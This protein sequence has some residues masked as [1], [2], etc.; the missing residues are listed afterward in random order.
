M[1]GPHPHPLLF[2]CC[3]T[4]NPACVHNHA[5]GT[6][7]PT[8]RA[9][10]R[11][12]S[13]AAA[14]GPPDAG[15][16]PASRAGAGAPDQTQLPGR[17]PELPRRQQRHHRDR[18]RDRGRG[19]WRVCCRGCCVARA[20]HLQVV[21]VVCCIVTRS[22]TQRPGVRRPVVMHVWWGRSDQAKVHAAGGCAVRRW[23]QGSHVVCCCGSLHASIHPQHNPIT[24]IHIDTRP[25]RARQTHKHTHQTITAAAHLCVSHACH[26]SCLLLLQA[27]QVAGPAAQ[28]G[29]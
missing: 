29:C 22:S 11:H 23:S 7:P 15:A 26:P 24:R 12:P 1:Q 4:S 20:R 17:P 28:G 21:F 13:A 27:H 8:S 9:A 2:L 14:P 10:P 5:T 3:I 6:P 19:R 25:Q 18:R 16:P